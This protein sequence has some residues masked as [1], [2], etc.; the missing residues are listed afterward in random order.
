MLQYSVDARNRKLRGLIDAIGDSPIL[1]IRTGP[2]PRS[3]DSPSAGDLIAAA[4]LPVRWFIDDG[5]LAK[6]GDWPTMIA[7][8]DGVAGHFRIFSGDGT[9]HIQGQ[10]ALAGELCE[11]T[12]SVADV[13][14]GQELAVTSF[15]ITAGNA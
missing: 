15:S 2:P 1:E 9:C 6:S 11:M 12:I 10:V 8:T 3:C 13:S 14:A 7:E 4:N 5:R